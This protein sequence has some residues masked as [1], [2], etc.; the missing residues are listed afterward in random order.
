MYVSSAWCGM[1]ASGTSLFL[2]RPRLVKT[3][4]NAWD[5]LHAPHTPTHTDPLYGA[6]VWEWEG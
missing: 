3:I 6:S 1:P 5:A 2:Y 4:S